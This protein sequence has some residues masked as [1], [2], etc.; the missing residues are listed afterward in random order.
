[1][2]G[3]RKRD[4]D[5]YFTT[6]M[7]FRQYAPALISSLV[8]SLGDMADGLVLGNTLGHIALAALALAMPVCQVFNTV[9]MALGIGGSV[10]FSTRMAQ[11][12]RDEAL[13]GFHGVVCFAVL[14][15]AAIALL[16]N[17]LLTPLLSLLGT[18]P[19][20]GRLFTAAAGYLRILLLGTPLLFLN[21]T[22][23][24]FLP[25]DNMEKQAS[26]AFTAGNIV[27]IVLNILLVLVLKMGVEGASIA[28]VAGQAVSSVLSLLAVR[29]HRGTLTLKHLRPDFRKA[30]KD[31]RIGLSCSVQYL[32]SIVSLLTVN[33]L[34]IRTSGSIGVAIFD[35]ILNLSC[36]M[37]NLFDAATKSA[38]PVV[39]TYCGERNRSGMK[40]AG[41]LCLKYTVI[42]GL[43]LALLVFLAPEAVVRLFGIDSPDILAQA[44]SALRLFACSIPVAALGIMLGDYYEACQQPGRTLFLVFF[45]SLLQIPVALALSSFLPG[46][47]WA[48]F[49][50]SE[51]LS[52]IFFMFW[53]K[54]RPAPADDEERIFRKTLYSNSAEIS[55]TTGEIM[56]FCERWNA[57]PLQQ[58]M[59]MM[60]MEELCIAMMENGFKGKADGFI[61]IV[62]LAGTD[63]IFE[64]HIRDNADSFNPLAMEPAGSVTDE[65]VNLNAI[66]IMA[67]KKKAKQFYYRHYQ[68]FNTLIIRI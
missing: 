22:L 17:L 48:L 43:V 47:F 39:S 34:L 44:R 49:L 38:L 27:D 42:S 37:T 21:Y 26:F 60:A 20:D 9:M 46:W 57:T 66:G 31:F 56:N 18:T 15:G 58:H 51:T 28:T 40:Q 35:V 41:I 62:L 1:M 7:F 5:H 45:R 23:H 59:T 16:G 63:G 67:I 12:Q 3:S 4:I 64:L 68:G 55:E 54:F 52:L 19:A 33:N 30:A 25:N 29:R 50:V 32:F 61:Q 14:F 10:R 13:S 65:N 53:Q 6:R 2:F 24:F 36:F 8:L 11:G